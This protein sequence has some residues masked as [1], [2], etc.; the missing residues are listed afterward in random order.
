MDFSEQTFE[1]SDSLSLLEKKVTLRFANDVL[2]GP[3]LVSRSAND[4]QKLSN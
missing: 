1:I 3:T 4:V 2:V